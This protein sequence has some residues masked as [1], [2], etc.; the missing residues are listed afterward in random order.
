YR[1]TV[2][3]EAQAWAARN[4]PSAEELDFLEEGV[5]EGRRQEAAQREIQARE[6]ALVQQS[7]AADRRAATRLRA[8]AGALGLSLLVAAG[9]T[10][11]ALNNAANATVAGTRAAASAQVASL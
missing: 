1:G 2:L 6:L 9:L 10:A 4:T 5:A 3:Q 7:A 11:I 8:L